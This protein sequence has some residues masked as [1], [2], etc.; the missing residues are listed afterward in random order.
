MT[1]IQPNANGKV[2]RARKRLRRHLTRLRSADSLTAGQRDLLFVEVL[3][4]LTRLQLHLM[5]QRE[6]DAS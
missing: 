1:N 4:D 5:G 2:Q 6:E 3:E